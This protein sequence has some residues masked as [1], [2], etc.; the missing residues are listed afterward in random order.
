MLK[1][2][3][4][5]RRFR[6]KFLGPKGRRL[7]LRVSFIILVFMLKFTIRLLVLACL[8]YFGVLVPTS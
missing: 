5:V 6:S 1:V 3:G 4:L 8:T 2:I 7:I